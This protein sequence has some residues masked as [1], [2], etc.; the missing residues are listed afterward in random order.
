MKKKLT[1][2]DGLR[3]VMKQIE[4]E[5]LKFTNE[6]IRQFENAKHADEMAKLSNFTLGPQRNKTNGNNS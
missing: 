3:K 6:E 2:A 5:G 1:F 4:K